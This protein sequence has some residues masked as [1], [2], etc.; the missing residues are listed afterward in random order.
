MAED[1]YLLDEAGEGQGEAGPSSVDVIEE[2]WASRK[3]LT[4]VR[5]F[6]RARRAGPWGV[7][8]VILARTVAAVPPTVTLP[9][10]VGGRMSLNLFTALV[11]P[12]GGGKGACEGSARDAVVCSYDP[13]G[14]TMVDIEEFPLGSG[15]G[16]A[17]TFRPAGIDDQ[18]LNS[19]DRAIFG[20][21]EIDTVAALFSRSGSTLEGE[22]RKLYSGEQIGFNNARKETRTVVAGHSYRAC[23]VVG[24]Q[25][26]RAQALLGGAD[27]GTPQRFLWMPV[28]D[29]DAPDTAPTEPAQWVVRMPRPNW[30]P[31]DL[32]IPDEAREAIDTARLVRLRGRDGE[33]DALDGHALLTRVK[34]AAALMALDGRTEVSEEDW[35]LAGVVMAMSNHTRARVQAASREQVRRAN[36]AR[37]LASAERDE[38]IGDR[39]FQRA[40]DRIL[41]WLDKGSLPRSEL[42]RKLKVDIRDNFGPAI[43][44]LMERGDVVELETDGKTVYARKQGH[45]G[46]DTEKPMSSSDN[47]CVPEG[48]GGGTRDTTA[49]AVQ[50]HV[51]LH[52]VPTETPVTSTEGGVSRV[53]RVPGPVHGAAVE[54]ARGKAIQLLSAH[55]EM[56]AR[57][58][59]RNLSRETRPGLAAALES[60]ATEGMIATRPEGDRTLYRLASGSGAA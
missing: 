28:T 16:I 15:E 30:K 52:S 47:K 7:L 56:S 42:H 22:L 37:A 35:Y 8:G 2:F 55:D 5:E 10:V 3:V 19:R 26:L 46:H 23:F 43:A 40:C 60:L 49:V 31:G 20:A 45:E 39:K 13:H 41:Y 6:A 33:P 29:P 27:G 34:V 38:V 50:G 18:E 51:S 4:H 32:V 24:V 12:S 44:E 59:R 36:H 1:A 14:L 53:S 11:G 9:P 57:E 58:M 54:R 48:H 25:P 17:R 21:P